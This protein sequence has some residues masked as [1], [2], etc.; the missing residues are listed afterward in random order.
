MRNSIISIGLFVCTMVIVFFLNNS[1]ITLCDEVHQRVDTME[2][3]ILN[4]DFESAFE[5]SMDLIDL[6]KGKNFEASIYIT[7]EYF[8]TLVDEAVKLSVFISY[9]D[10]V[11]ANAT[12]HYIKNIAENMKNLQIPTLENI[13]SKELNINTLFL[14]HFN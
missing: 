13:L 4:D 1:L 5:Q 8:D 3:T 6:L 10:D 9:N 2:E 14:L 7:H 12:L 11:D